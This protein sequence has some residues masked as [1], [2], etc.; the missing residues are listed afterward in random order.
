MS[1]HNLVAS[2]FARTLRPTASMARSTVARGK[3]TIPTSQVNRFQKSELVT[4]SAIFMGF[5]AAGAFAAKHDVFNI[6]RVHL[7]QVKQ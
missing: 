5:M 4:A 2:M 1:Y 7:L 3:S 6:A